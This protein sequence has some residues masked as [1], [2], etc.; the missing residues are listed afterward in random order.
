M[1]VSDGIT[2][3]HVSMNKKIMVLEKSEKGYTAE[4]AAYKAGSKPE[5]EDTDDLLYRTRKSGTISLDRV[6]VLARP[7][8]EWIQMLLEIWRRVRDDLF[9]DPLTLQ[10]FDWKEALKTA[11]ST[12]PRINTR[13]EFAVVLSDMLGELGVSHTHVSIGDDGRGELD[14]DHLPGVLGADFSEWN[15][16]AVHE[17]QSIGKAIRGRLK[18]LDLYTE[19][20]LT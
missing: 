17:I 5:D 6:R 7:K 2:D 1:L 18:I 19:Q 12:L 10:N 20:V 13:A 16:L 3:V 9:V 11:V 15:E 8:D 4:L 14:R